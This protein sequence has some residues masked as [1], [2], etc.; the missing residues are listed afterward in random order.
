MD[1]EGQQ[2]DYHDQMQMEEDDEYQQIELDMEGNELDAVAINQPASNG[3][4]M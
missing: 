4:H 1:E 3:I 2:E